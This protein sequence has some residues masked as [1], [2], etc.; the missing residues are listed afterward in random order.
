MIDRWELIRFQNSDGTNI[1]EP[2][3]GETPIILNFL[4]NLDFHATTTSNEINGNF[5]TEQ[6]KLIITNFATTLVSETDWGIMFYEA[7]EAARDPNSLEIIMEF[8]VSS[9]TLRLSYNENKDMV[10]IRR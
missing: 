8:S 9:E 1:V 7:L 2:Q 5:T 3:T 6:E 4:E 10:L